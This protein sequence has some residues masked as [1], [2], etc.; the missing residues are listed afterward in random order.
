MT[1]K[2]IDTQASKGR[3]EAKHR[4]GTV[5]NSMKW[6]GKKEK[7]EMWTGTK[8]VRVLKARLRKSAHTA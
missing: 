6:T 1:I 3:D 2:T 7:L 8:S 5:G 4:P